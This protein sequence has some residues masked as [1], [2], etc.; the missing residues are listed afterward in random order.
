MTKNAI[1]R[2][3]TGVVMTD[4]GCWEWTGHKNHGYGQITVEKR[5]V[6]T[7]R[8]IYKFFHGEL[9]EGLQINHLCKNKACQNPDHLEQ[10]SPRENC[11]YSREEFMLS[12]RNRYGSYES[13]N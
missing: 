12:V 2:I 6:R 7:H 13:R 5:T 8:L 4:S 3:I 1:E 9:V 11:N 10:V